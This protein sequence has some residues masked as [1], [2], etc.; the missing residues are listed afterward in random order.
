MPDALADAPPTF[1]ST[2]LLSAADLA[3]ELRLSVRTVRRMDSS[4]ALPR[5]IRL[6]SGA[7]RWRR[8]DIAEWIAAG[9]PRR[10]EV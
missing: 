7:V 4:G 9:C 10:G 5:P 1:G 2:L 6:S 8:I 3:R